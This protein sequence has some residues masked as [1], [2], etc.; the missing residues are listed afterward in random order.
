MGM[1]LFL[2]IISTLIMLTAT[3]SRGAAPATND[4]AV[5]GK[6]KG[7]DAIAACG[8]LIAAGT[9]RGNE[10]ARIYLNRCVAW[11]RMRESDRAMAD[12]NEALRLNPKYAHGYANR[13]WAWT[14]K[15]E[16]DSAMTDCN[17][18]IR[19]DRIL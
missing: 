9:K 3:A 13:C 7:D 1:R 4:N 11:S 10:L 6:A 5:C 14:L 12:C 15:N 2:A 17:E 18:A 8:R 16:P 19:L